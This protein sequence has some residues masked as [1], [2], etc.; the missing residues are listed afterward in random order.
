M[1]FQEFLKAKGTINSIFKRR[2]ELL[3]LGDVSK[4][5]IQPKKVTK[6]ID[7]LLFEWFSKKRLGFHL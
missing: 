6:K 7:T 1:N 4:N 2:D 3:L 5:N